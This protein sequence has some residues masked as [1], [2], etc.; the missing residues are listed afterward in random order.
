MSKTEEFVG[1]SLETLLDDVA[2][3]LGVGRQEIRYQIVREQRGFLGVPVRSVAIRVATPAPRL[4]S[5]RRPTRRRGGRGPSADR[6][7][8]AGPTVATLE[9]EPGGKAAPRTERP[10]AGDDVEAPVRAERD[11]LAEEDLGADHSAPAVLEML[12]AMVQAM[13]LELDLALAEEPGRLVVNLSGADREIVLDRS[14]ETLD[15]MQYI[16]SRMARRQLGTRKRVQLE[17]EGFRSIRED[18]IRQMAV[19][20]ADKVEHTGAPVRLPLLNP[21]E[22]RIVH[23]TLSGRD[24][25]ST[26][27]EGDGFAKRVTVRQEPRAGVRSRLS[28]KQDVPR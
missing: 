27:S 23:V 22:R 13:G 2:V 26:E 28:R 14:G 9:V 18:E 16:A 11:T 20:A 6:Q 12:R 1:G 5:A 10:D 19:D 21:Y 4:E 3:R 15:A 25:V 17:S 24:G 7:R 8:Q